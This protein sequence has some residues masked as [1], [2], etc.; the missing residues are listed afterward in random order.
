[1]PCGDLRGRD[2]SLRKKARTDGELDSVFATLAQLRVGG[3]VISSDSFF[4][5]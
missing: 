4:F 5:T 3:L 1:M 2:D